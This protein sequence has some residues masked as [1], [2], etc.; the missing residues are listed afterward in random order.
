MY[1]REMEESGWALRI[2]GEIGFINLTHSI[3]M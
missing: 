2:G 1:T 3:A